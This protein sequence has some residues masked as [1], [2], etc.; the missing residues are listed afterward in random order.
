MPEHRQ[1]TGSGVL[2]S[3][4]CR[5]TVRGVVNIFPSDIQQEHN[6]VETF[7]PGPHTVVYPSGPIARKDGDRRA[8]VRAAEFDVADDEYFQVIRR[9]AGDGT[10]G[11]PA[12]VGS[13]VDYLDAYAAAADRG[14]YGHRCE[15]KVMVPTRAEVFAAGP[16]GTQVLIGESLTWQPQ[17]IAER[18]RLLGPR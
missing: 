1:R 18:L 8:T 5:V 16:D 7:S 3:R 2:G 6:G 4:N 10:R 15:I 14:A 13:Y 12:G 9:K 11:G 17:P